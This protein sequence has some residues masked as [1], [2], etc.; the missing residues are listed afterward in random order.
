MYIYDT[1]GEGDKDFMIAADDI[2]KDIG[3][4][5][6]PVSILAATVAPNIR[7][8]IRYL[9]RADRAFV[10]SYVVHDAMSG[11]ALP[12]F[13]VLC[14]APIAPSLIHQVDKAHL[15]LAGILG[16]VFVVRELISVDD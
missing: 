13:F 10:S 2:T 14:L 5:I 9:R 8:L 6:H 1:C 11:F 16:I 12:S 7:A 3:A 4:W 15:V